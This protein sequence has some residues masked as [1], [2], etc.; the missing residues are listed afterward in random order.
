MINNINQDNNYDDEDVEKM[1]NNLN[2][3]N[4]YTTDIVKQYFKQLKPQ[5]PPE[6]ERNLAIEIRKGNTEAKDI[7]IERNLRLVV[8]IAKR[9]LNNGLPFLDLIQEGNI[10]L[11]KAVDR[12]DVTKGFKFSTYATHWIRQ[13][14]KRGIEN[15][16]RNIRVP[17]HLLES[18]NK[19]KI[20]QLE[21]QKKLGREPN[22][23]EIAEELRISYKE[24][25]KLN[26]LQS[27]TISMNKLV[28]EDE[29]SELEKYIPDVS[30]NPENKVLENI[31]KLEIRE[32]LEKCNLKQKEIDVLKLRY[33]L[34][35]E[36]PKS[37]QEIGDIYNVSRERIRQIENKALAK[38]RRSKYVKI[39]AEYTDDP[40]NVL[41]NISYYNEKYDNSIENT[42]KYY[43]EYIN[44]KKRKES[45]E[46]TKEERNNK[47][48]KLKTIYEYLNNYSEEEINKVI[49]Q[50]DEKEKEV[51]KLR[52]GNDLYN[53]Q[54]HPE[55]T[56]KHKNMFYNVIIPK[57]KLI[58]ETQK[59]TNQEEV[60][61][62][63]NI[64]KITQNIEKNNQI[65]KTKEINTIAK[66]DYVKMLEL[67]KTPV[68]EKMRNSLAD[69]EAL[70]ISL[71]FG[72]I[73][74]KCFSTES[75]ANFLG[76][77]YKEVNECIKKSLLSYKKLINNFIDE[78][79]NTMTDEQNIKK[80]F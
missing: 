14:I 42:K 35:N 8:S 17:S 53:P 5:L 60:S 18:I 7:F 79:I 37:L 22:I 23:D 71:K 49:A 57:M 30:N 43:K 11:M 55:L 21:L 26:K 46:K 44:T 20:V 47:M 25:V 72:Y 74:G 78:A 29:E 32:L 36:Q 10:G 34:E 13:S 65:Q 67:L 59:N 64:K 4:D 63:N 38:I 48:K 33:G 68:F 28:G 19:Y 24:A 27:D 3:D 70:I 51:I 77:D 16:G 58:L 2:E 73:D 62:N 12:Y 15:N 75:I 1:Y 54:P 41:K 40:Q 80:K 39:F 61:Q 76:I 45:S 66:E 6:E 9:Y 52:Y 69:K 31:M 50:L 56:I